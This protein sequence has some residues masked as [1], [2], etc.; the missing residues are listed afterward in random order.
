M[1]RMVINCKTCAKFCVS[2]NFFFNVAQTFFLIE[3][4]QK[5][6]MKRNIQYWYRTSD[7]LRVFDVRIYWPP[8]WLVVSLLN[9]Y[10][11]PKIASNRTGQKI[12]PNGPVVSLRLVLVVTS[13]FGIKKKKKTQ[14]EKLIVCFIDFPGKQDIC[15]NYKIKII[16]SSYWM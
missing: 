2:V 9:Y 16:N 6:L 11:F 10:L 13:S 14:E 7:K 1:Y 4:I 12:M 15:V 3:I 8:S 5:E